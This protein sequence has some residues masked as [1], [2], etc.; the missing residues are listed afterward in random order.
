LTQLV[1]YFL[2]GSLVS[3]LYG[4]LK[5]E[6]LKI[7]SRW[8]S[9]QLAPLNQD[10]DTDKF[11]NVLKDFTLMRE[12]A[13]PQKLQRLLRVIVRKV[14]WMPDNKHR[15]HYYILNS[16][17]NGDRTGS[18]SGLNTGSRLECDGQSEQKPNKASG[19]CQRLYVFRG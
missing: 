11:L 9:A 6:Q 17:K 4:V 7:E 18:D 2:S 8:L 3:L 13:D 5:R 1:V 15:A 12:K 19:I 16:R 14:E 10:F